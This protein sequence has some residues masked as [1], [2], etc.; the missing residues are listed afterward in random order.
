MVLAIAA[1]TNWEVLQLD[2]QTAFLKSEHQ[3]GDARR[4]GPRF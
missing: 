1:E 4:R 3:M 2:V